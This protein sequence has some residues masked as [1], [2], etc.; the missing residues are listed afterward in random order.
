MAMQSGPAG[1]AIYM[2]FGNVAGEAK[3]T[4]PISTS[5]ASGGWIALT[6]CSYGG[7]VSRPQLTAAPSEFE[8]EAQPVKVTK[9]TDASTISLLREALMGNFKQPVVIVFVRTGEGSA[10]EYLR[11]EMENCGITDF[12]MSGG[13]DRQSES[14]EI[15]CS[16]MSIT[17]WRFNGTTRGAQSVVTLSNEAGL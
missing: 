9:V 16:T 2:C 11:I 13:E 4:L 12:S 7:S 17:T 5:P 10:A 15:R 3:T 1:E 8:G 14:Y 6:S